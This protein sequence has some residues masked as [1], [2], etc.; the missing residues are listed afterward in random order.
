[1]DD[2]RVA[3]AMSCRAEEEVRRPGRESARV[4][5]GVRSETF[6]GAW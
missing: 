4:G 6:T 1:M 3:L 2:D 5:G